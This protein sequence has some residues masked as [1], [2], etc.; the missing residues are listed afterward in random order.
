MAVKMR[1]FKEDTEPNIDQSHKL[2]CAPYFCLSKFRDQVKF[3][4]TEG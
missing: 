4:S 3:A 2:Y 1:Y